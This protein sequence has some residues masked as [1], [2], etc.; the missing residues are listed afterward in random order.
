MEKVTG[1]ALFAPSAAR[2]NLAHV[3]ECIRDEFTGCYGLLRARTR[4][5]SSFSREDGA[6]FRRMRRSGYWVRFRNWQTGPGERERERGSA[7]E[8][9]CRVYFGRAG[10][11]SDRVAAGLLANYL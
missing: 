3:I 10:L 11:N 9:F 2:F 4:V 7:A 6:R 8:Q 1:S 5:V